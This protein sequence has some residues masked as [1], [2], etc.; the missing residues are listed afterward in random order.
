V[1]GLGRVGSDVKDSG[2]GRELK[3]QG[4]AGDSFAA[5][6]E[7]GFQSPR[8]QRALLLCALRCCDVRYAVLNHGGVGSGITAS[9][10]PGASRF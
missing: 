10:G 8:S 5:S 6:T 1:H 3:Q 7:V 4:C 2:G 9:A